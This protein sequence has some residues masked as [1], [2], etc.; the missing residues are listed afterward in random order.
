MELRNN[1]RQTQLNLINECTKIIKIA[2]SID[3]ER[4]ETDIKLKDGNEQ[5]IDPLLKAHIC[6]IKADYLRIV[7]ECL[8]GINGL[9]SQDDRISDD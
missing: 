1:I 2:I 7:Y 5:L 6:K 9:L 4:R 8:D 3:D